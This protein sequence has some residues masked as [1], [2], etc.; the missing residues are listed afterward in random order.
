M[1]KSLNEPKSGIY[2][3]LRVCVCKWAFGLTWLALSFALLCT[4]N[5][6][7]LALIA[8]ILNW[9]VVLIG[10]TVISIPGLLCIHRFA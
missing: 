10:I 3:P 8:L 7:Y 5:W 2:W 4:V 6:D 9:L 1:A